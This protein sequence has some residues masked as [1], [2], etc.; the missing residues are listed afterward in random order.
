VNNLTD[1]KPETDFFKTKRFAFDRADIAKKKIDNLLKYYGTEGKIRMLVGPSGVGKSVLAESQANKYS[2]LMKKNDYDRPVLY[3]RLTSG[4]SPKG[5][6]EALILALGVKPNDNQTK[7]ES[8]LVDLLKNLNVK[9]IIIDE[10]QHVLPNKKGSKTTQMVADTIKNITDKSLI[11]ML[12]VGLKTSLSIVENTF[13]TRCS[14]I[15]EEED[16]LFRRALSPIIIEGIEY[17]DNLLMGKTMT[18]FE[19]IFAEVNKKFGKSIMNL[20]TGEFQKRM[21]AA[22]LG[23][24]GRMS[25]ILSESLEFLNGKQITYSELALAY[26]EVNSWDKGGINPF[27]CDEK[28]LDRLI[29]QIAVLSKRKKN[30]NKEVA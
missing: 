14:E 5:I 8:Q 21:W 2:R 12:L 1:F 7:L 15:Q 30:K 25:N 29:K 4:S 17:G 20:T 13:S 18:G 3:L 28:D 19:L 24:I 22:S 11:P 27:S 26:D 23:Y 10:M 9:L 16:Q 6:C